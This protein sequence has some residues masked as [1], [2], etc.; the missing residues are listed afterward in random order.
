M[1]LFVDGETYNAGAVSAIRRVKNAAGVA[2]AVLDH[3]RHTMLA[4]NLA[5]LFAYEMGFTNESLHSEQSIAQ[6]NSWLSKNCQPNFWANVSPDPT[7]NCGPYTPLSAKSF[8]N[9]VITREDLGV[10]ED[11]HDTIGM[12][13]IDINNKKLLELQQMGCG[14]KSLGG[15][16]TL[17]Y[18]ELE[19]ILAMVVVQLQ[20]AMET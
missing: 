13:A 16:E 3:T 20:L 15:S 14:I 9:D 8:E 18:L 10:G 11:N 19:P 2:R 12:V 7:K 1:V 17:P 4:G 6:H 5:A